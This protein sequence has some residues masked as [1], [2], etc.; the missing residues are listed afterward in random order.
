MI[1]KHFVCSLLTILVISTSWSLP[2]PRYLT[3]PNWQN[4][5]SKVTR[6]TAQFV[7]LPSRKP[8]YCPRSSWRTL[9]RQHLMERC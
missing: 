9:V 8:A 1:K 6:G 3:V 7:C 2:A 5:V 4:C